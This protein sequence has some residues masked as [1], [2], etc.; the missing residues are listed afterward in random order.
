MLTSC[1]S[2]R[3]GAGVWRAQQ[4]VWRGA[5]RLGEAQVSLTVCFALEGPG[6][7]KHARVGAGLQLV[8]WEQDLNQERA[9]AAVDLLFAACEHVTAVPCPHQCLPRY[10]INRCFPRERL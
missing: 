7:L 9:A 2:L 1:L 10:L 6:G 4:A 5:V 8:A 3:L